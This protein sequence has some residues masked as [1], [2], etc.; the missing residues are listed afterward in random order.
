M[1]RGFFTFKQN[2]FEEQ[3]EEPCK[4]TTTEG[5]ESS[6][7]DLEFESICSGE[8][9]GY[10]SG[11]TLAELNETRSRSPLIN[12]EMKRLH[13]AAIQ[14]VGETSN[15][16]KPHQSTLLGQA[17]THSV[18]EQQLKT[19]PSAS[20]C[21]DGFIPSRRDN[22]EQL[23]SPVNRSEPIRVPGR[24]IQTAQAQQQQQQMMG[25]SPPSSQE[26]KEFLDGYKTPNISL[27]LISPQFGNN[28]Q[29]PSREYGTYSPGTSG[30][31]AQD[32]RQQQG[33]ALNEEVS[34]EL[35]SSKEEETTDQ[36]E[37]SEDEDFESEEE[38]EDAEDYTPNEGK[39]PTRRKGRKS[40]SEDM[41]PNPSKLLSIGRELD[42][43]NKIISDLK[44]INELPQQSRGRSRKEKNK[45]ASRYELRQDVFIDLSVFLV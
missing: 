19:Q 37:G 11:P 24:D 10:K 39:T 33:S 27:Q 7:L 45:L 40:E 28:Y 12:P 1:D 30:T 25:V 3:S 15:G 22:S 36:Y 31:T 21:Y 43:L 14:T 35:R 26:R 38:M 20:I 13:Q 17:K 34:D 29:V 42:R 32:F 41:V 2:V 23:S 9:N 5:L 16:G 8:L 4:A 44:P 18:L 6:L